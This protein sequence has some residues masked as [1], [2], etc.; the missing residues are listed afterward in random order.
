MVSCVRCAYRAF[1][2]AT[3]F[4]RAHSLPSRK[5]TYALAYR[6]FSAILRSTSTLA[7]RRAHL[8]AAR[9]RYNIAHGTYRKRVLLKAAWHHDLLHRLLTPPVDTTV[10]P[11]PP[12]TLR[13]H[14][15]YMFNRPSALPHLPICADFLQDFRV[16]P[17]ALTRDLSLPLSQKE[18]WAA[19]AGMRNTTAPGMCGLEVGLLLTLFRVPLFATLLTAA[20]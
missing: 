18:V 3:C 16:A 5:P 1:W 19:L 10:S 4:A 8:R 20:L 13:A 9:Y 14:F 11:C 2:L 15:D 17:P 7:T 6:N 12:G